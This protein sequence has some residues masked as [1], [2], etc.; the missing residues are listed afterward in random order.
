MPKPHDPDSEVVPHPD[1]DRSQRRRF[2]AEQK[3]QILDEAEAC[4]WGQ[5]GPY[6]RSKGIYSAQLASCKSQRAKNGLEGLTSSKPGP[7]STKDPSARTI[8]AQQ[9][10]IAALEKELRISRALIELQKKAHEILEIALPT[11]ELNDE[12]ECTNWSE[13]GEKKSP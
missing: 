1:N 4:Q 7:K 10:K 13:T 11:A 5:L 8:Q 9:R 6:L 3:A 12:G 2:T